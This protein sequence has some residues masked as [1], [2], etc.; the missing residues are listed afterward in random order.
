M[1]FGD[2]SGED[3]CFGYLASAENT[4]KDTGQC[5][6]ACSI[7]GASRC[8]RTCFFNNDSQYVRINVRENVMS[9]DRNSEAILEKARLEAK[10]IVEDAELKAGERLGQTAMQQE[11]RFKELKLP[12]YPKRR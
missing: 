4:G 9:I 6:D 7:R 8:T 2:V 12:F 5:D 1:F 11:M 3:L 10:E